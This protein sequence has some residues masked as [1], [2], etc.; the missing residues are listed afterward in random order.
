MAK[1]FAALARLL[2]GRHS[3]AADAYSLRDIGLESYH[4]ALADH[5][6]EERRAALRLR[7]APLG[8]P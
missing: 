1:I 6:Q 4:P 5:M 8:L 7:A 3:A 2:V